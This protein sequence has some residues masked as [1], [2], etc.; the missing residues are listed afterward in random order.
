[1]ATTYTFWPY[2]NDS[3]DTLKEKQLNNAAWDEIACDIALLDAK[4]NDSKCTVNEKR[5]PVQDKLAYLCILIIWLL[6]LYFIYYIIDTYFTN[7]NKNVNTLPK[8]EYP[9]THKI[10]IV[11]HFIGGIIIMLIGP[12]QFIPYFR[13]NIIHKWNGR[14]YLSCCLITSLAGLIFICVNGT[15]GGIVM[16]IAFATSGILLF[17][18]GSI[19][20]YYGYYRKKDKHRNWAV[21]TFA[22]GIAPLFYRILY[23]FSYIG[24]YD[25]FE[26]EFKGIL[27]YI[28]DWTYFLLPLIVA[29]IIIKYV[30]QKR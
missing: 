3:I 27:D 6:G 2:D 14:I 24:D 8:L 17:T 18:F 11:T 7:L 29:E 15:V 19:T 4:N 10:L 16:D 13:K 28:F 22:L 23:L 26:Y 25:P 21:R 20:W 1:M 9:L 5:K 12:I 30:M